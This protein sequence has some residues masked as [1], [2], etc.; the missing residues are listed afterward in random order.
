[1]SAEIHDG[2][3][4]RG[5]GDLNIYHEQTQGSLLLADDP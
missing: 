2:I 3:D 1:M 4:I 5:R